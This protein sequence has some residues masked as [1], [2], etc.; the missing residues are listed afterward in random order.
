MSFRCKRCRGPQPQGTRPVWSYTYRVRD[1]EPRLNANPRY[2]S[3]REKDDGS[4]PAH[5]SGGI[6]YEIETASMICASCAKKE[7][8]GGTTPTHGS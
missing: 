6:G 1:Y 5:D 7:A 3:A 2:R 8:A 4:H